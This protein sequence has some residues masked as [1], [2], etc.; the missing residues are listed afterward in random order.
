[1]VGE[2]MRNWEERVIRDKA[3]LKAESVIANEAPD[4]DAKEKL[5]DAAD[6]LIS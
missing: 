3:N 5:K 4:E 1:M 6:K 2:W